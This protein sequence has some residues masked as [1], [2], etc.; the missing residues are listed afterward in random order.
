MGT[1]GVDG[2][3]GARGDDRTKHEGDGGSQPT[4]TTAACRH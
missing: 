3:V 4:E 2:V 1:K